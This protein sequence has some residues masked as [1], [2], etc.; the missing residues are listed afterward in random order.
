MISMD[1]SRS[2]KCENIGLNVRKQAFGNVR[3][4]MILGENILSIYAHVR[5]RAC[6]HKRACM[7]TFVLTRGMPAFFI[8][9]QVSALTFILLEWTF[10]RALNNASKWK[11]E[12]NLVA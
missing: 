7:Y 10:G 3:R 6:V 2:L 1:S 8:Y 11:M 9:W 12:F 5:V 4:I